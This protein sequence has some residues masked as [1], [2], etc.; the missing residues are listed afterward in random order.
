MHPAQADAAPAPI[1]R[2]PWAG[3]AF[4]SLAV[5]MIMLD[6]TIVNVA[7]PWMAFDLA[8]T[9]SDTQ[10]VV[11]SYS[12]AFASLLIL[13]GRLA[14]LLGRRRVL[15]IGVSAFVVAS[16]AIGLAGTTSQII[17]WRLIQGMSASLIMP[18][19]LSLIHASFTG[20]DRSTAFAVWGG[21]IGGMA[22][23]GPL[24]G[25]W[26]TTYHSWHWAFFANLPVGALVMVGL[27]QTMPESRDARA[28]RLT[29]VPGVV[30]SSAALGGIVFALIEGQ[31]LGWVT[32]ITRLTIGPV[33]VP[34]GGPSPVLLAGIAGIACAAA[35]LVVERRRAHASLDILLDLR[36]FAIP[37]FRAGTLVALIV[38]LGEF[39]LLFVLPLFVQGVLGYN[40]MQTGVLL[41]A[42]AAGSFLASGASTRLAHR[43]GAIRVLQ[44]GMALEAIGIAGMG[45]AIT[46]DATRASLAPSLLV[47]GLGIG[48]ATAQLTGVI[49]RDVPVDR[50]GQAA[51]VQSTSRQVGA[52]V[53]TAIL[54]A[55]L[56][57]A[58]SAQVAANLVQRGVDAARATEIATFV[59]D[60]AGQL[61][62]FLILQPEGQSL[63]DGAH[64]GFT[65]ATRW[66]ALVATAFV[67]LGLAASL[68][69]PAAPANAP[70]AES[71]LS[72]G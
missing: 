21:T 67:L 39:G 12:L 59:T 69:L 13:S 53:G 34:V 65:S 36:L 54:G 28:T 3:L 35:Y 22:A 60:T 4:V 42:L 33:T 45:L 30:L 40:P 41:L 1:T 29:D 14:D 20:R 11:A 18:A 52:A 61:M 44:I 58:T 63:V 5:S 15:L 16:M 48:F 38:S 49:L 8:F 32:A 24:V 57:A 47:Y 25:G 37:S 19:S 10:W 26:V 27:L 51:A 2:P 50:S 56:A 66:V 17:L 70:D 23:L 55:T 31:R 9:T 72:R 64:L 7:L 62:Q 71:G 6:T 43:I 46:V 68:R